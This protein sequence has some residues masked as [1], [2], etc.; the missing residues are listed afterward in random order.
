MDFKHS[1]T[2]IF[3]FCL[4]VKF[5]SGLPYVTQKDD[6]RDSVSLVSK[7]DK[8]PNLT[9]NLT[10]SKPAD[11]LTI[12]D[13]NIAVK[14]N[15]TNKNDKIDLTLQGIN[16]N[17]V[18]NDDIENEYSASEIKE[19]IKKTVD[20]PVENS[21][22]SETNNYIT[23]MFPNQNANKQM[24][25]PHM[26][27]A[28]VQKLENSP[29]KHGKV[30][31]I[32]VYDSPNQNGHSLSGHNVHKKLSQNA[33]HNGHKKAVGYIAVVFVNKMNPQDAIHPTRTQHKGKSNGNYQH[34]L[35][36]PS[37]GMNNQN[38]IWPPGKGLQQQ[39]GKSNLDGE[40]YRLLEQAKM[41]NP[42][43]QWQNNEVPNSN[44]Q[45]QNPENVEWQNLQTLNSGNG[46]WQNTQ[47]LNT[48]S[49][50]WKN[51]ENGQWQNPQVLNPDNG[52]WQNLQSPNAGNDQWQNHQVLNSDSEQWQNQIPSNHGNEKLNS[53]HITH[54]N[55]QPNFL[56][57]QQWKN[58]KKSNPNTPQWKNQQSSIPNNA[59]WH[60]N[61]LVV[62]GNTWKQSPGANHMPQMPEFQGNIIYDQKHWSQNQN[63]NTGQNKYKNPN[64][65]TVSKGNS[66]VNPNYPVSGN[67]L[68]PTRGK[69]QPK[70]VMALNNKNGQNFHQKKM[71]K[72]NAIWIDENGQLHN[73]QNHGPQQGFNKHEISLSPS[74]PENHNKGSIEYLPIL[75]HV[76]IEKS[77]DGNNNHHTSDSDSMY[78]GG[79]QNDLPNHIPNFVP[80]AIN[81]GPGPN[82]HYGSKNENNLNFNVVSPQMWKSIT[83]SGKHEYPEIKFLQ[84][85]NNFLQSNHHKRN[86][87]PYREHVLGKSIVV[88]G[89]SVSTKNSETLKHGNHKINENAQVNQH[90][91]HVFPLQSNEIHQGSPINQDFSNDPQIRDAFRVAGIYLQNRKN[92]Q[93]TSNDLQNP[94]S[95]LH[96]VNSNA[97]YNNEARNALSSSSRD[98]KAT[99]DQRYNA[100]VHEKNNNLNI[101]KANDHLLQPNSPDIAQLFGQVPNS[102]NQNNRI[103]QIFNNPNVDLSKFNE[104]KRFPDGAS[105]NT[106]SELFKK[107]D[108]NLQSRHQAFTNQ[109]LD[110]NYSYNADPRQNQKSSVAANL[111]QNDASII[112]GYGQKD[113]TY[114]S[115]E[116]NLPDRS[117]KRSYENQ[118]SGVLKAGNRDDNQ[119][120]D[121]RKW[122]QKYSENY[123]FNSNSGSNQN[124]KISNFKNADGSDS[125]GFGGESFF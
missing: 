31:Y 74:V 120:D 60:G 10:N 97:E 13:E 32:P 63:I 30:V 77:A 6:D 102:I 113:T 49:G 34:Q 111:E 69:P 104:L 100:L 114:E 5:C 112:T 123:S 82:N 43:I 4:T 1:Y 37:R 94:H 14:E 41:K 64:Q 59:Q 8:E 35:T 28:V 21:K 79:L 76:V 81:Q 19:S 29:H 27:G 84:A 65:G 71:I 56:G 52:Q 91:P 95:Q 48:D 2:I 38:S 103:Q 36:H 85:Q 51:P 24:Y 110:E 50:Q 58:Q 118:R 78:Q 107:N 80:N 66:K 89:N 70:S 99:T 73:N 90:T 12:T 61:T 16:S 55:Q 83:E 25:N 40:D 119:P 108:E 98:I 62:G 11:L 22:T 44:M 116:R 86:G 17:N 109:N 68:F 7:N 125:D 3:V 72:G 57:G 105:R 46:Q 20:Q 115:S 33:Q 122:Q 18:N 23:H 93:T 26:G 9:I 53:K 92:L 121:S 75:Q 117:D 45:W 39:P 87:V 67:P 88:N 124:S 101:V 15:I 96:P 47:V 106:V 54:H 42:Q